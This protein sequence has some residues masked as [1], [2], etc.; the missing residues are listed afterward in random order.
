[1]T[2]KSEKV[3]VNFGQHVNAVDSINKCLGY[4]MQ[5]LY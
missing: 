2:N 3:L 5:H 4:H 1:L